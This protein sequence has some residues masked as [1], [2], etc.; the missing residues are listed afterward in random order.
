MKI[1]W[2]IFRVLLKRE[3]KHF[4]Q[5]HV[6][7]EK[8]WQFCD[9]TSD[10]LV[11]VNQSILTVSEPCFT[12]LFILS[13]LDQTQINLYWFFSALQGIPTSSLTPISYSSLHYME[14]FKEAKLLKEG[15][16]H[17]SLI[18]SVKSTGFINATA[19]LSCFWKY[20]LSS[21]QVTWLIFTPQ[22]L[23]WFLVHL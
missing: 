22:I 23:A 8:K 19:R 17:P 9:T 21:F 7:Y 15:L 2:L 10:K 11:F 14:D 4:L 3:L 6:F 12:F 18:F 1:T 5:G 20:I 16:Y 13:L